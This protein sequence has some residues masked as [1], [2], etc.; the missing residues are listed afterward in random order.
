MGRWKKMFTRI[1]RYLS[2]ALTLI[3][4][5]CKISSTSN[6]E[7]GNKNKVNFIISGSKETGIQINN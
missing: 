3:L 5:G 7:D 2:I 4:L 1:Y 6:L